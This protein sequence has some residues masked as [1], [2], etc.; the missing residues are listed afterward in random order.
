MQF[1]VITELAYPAPIV[2]KTVTSQDFI[3]QANEYSGVTATVISEE[4]G[5][6]K[7]TVVSKVDYIK[8]LPK[9]AAQALGKSHLSYTMEQVFHEE[10]MKVDWTI[11]LPELGRKF[12]ATGSLH[13]LDKNP[14]P[15]SHRID[16][17]NIQ[18]KIPF[19]GSKIEREI[20]KTLE[21]SYNKVG[22][23][24]KEYLQKQS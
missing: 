1:S 7:R 20:I 22:Q 10:R 3:Q 21:A 4:Q 13:I 14:S 2:W 9:P 5:T 23:F 17:G 8:P 18:V 6:G 11:Q 24:T 12:S 19:F 16:S 15:L